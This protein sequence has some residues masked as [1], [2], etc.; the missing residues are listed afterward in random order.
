MT[1]T[2]EMTMAELLMAYPGA[3]RALFRQYHIGGCSSCGFRQDE[4]VA[5]VCARNDGLDPDAVLETVRAAHEDDL[6]MLIEPTEARDRV[7]AGEAEILDLRTAEE[8]EAVHVEGSRH[9]NQP[10]MQEILGSWP[11]DRLLILLDHQGTRCLD[12]ASYF[13]GHGLTNVKGLRGGIDA[14]SLEVDPSLPRYTLE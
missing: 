14:W 10:L 3:Q 8:Y 6:K 2:S 4:T 13:A 1:V 12:A 7:A 5:E 9:F 11:K